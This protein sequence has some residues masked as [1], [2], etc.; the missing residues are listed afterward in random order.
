MWGPGAAALAVA[1]LGRWRHPRTITF[2]GGSRWWSAAFFVVPLMTLGIVYAPLVGI[3]AAAVGVLA[4]IGFFNILGEELGWR[5]YLQDALR[6]LPR[7]WRYLAIGV[8]WEFWHFTNRTHGSDVGEIAR[9]LLVSYP[10]V[11]ALS[12]V[13]GEATDRARALVVSVSL[14]FWIDALFEVPRLLNGPTWPTYLVFGLSIVFWVVLLWK[15]PLDRVRE[16][17]VEGSTA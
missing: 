5:G 7:I 10:T 12:V 6:H 4:V 16:P 1:A 15:W 2:F 8:L 11:I 14:H 3:R 13:I 17:V 9:G